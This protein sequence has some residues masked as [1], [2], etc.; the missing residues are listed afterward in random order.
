MAVFE[1]V[2]LD[3]LHG[4]AVFTSGLTG[5][6][7]HTRNLKTIKIEGDLKTILLELTE[8]KWFTDDMR[9]R[10]E[11]SYKRYIKQNI[12]SLT[13]TFFTA[14]ARGLFYCLKFL[15]WYNYCAC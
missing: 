14:L 12:V 15:V 6:V 8:R 7:L 2:E 10:I 11:D 3:I 4:V 13:R 1:G 5:H 9:I